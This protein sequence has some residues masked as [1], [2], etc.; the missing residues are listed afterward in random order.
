M[1]DRKIHVEENQEGDGERGRS[2]DNEEEFAIVTS[3][4]TNKAA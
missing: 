1:N 2:N 3:A 4:L